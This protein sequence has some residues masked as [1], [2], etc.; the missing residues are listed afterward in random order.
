MPPTPHPP[1]IERLTD[2]PQGRYPLHIGTCTELDIK[3][4][5]QGYDFG[6]RLVHLVT[7]ETKV[8][9][10]FALPRGI[11]LR[12]LA[13]YLEYPDEYGNV[14]ETGV[15]CDRAIVWLIEESGPV[16]LTPR[17]AWVL[18]YVFFTLWPGQK[19]FDFCLPNTKH[20]IRC[21]GQF[22]FLKQRIWSAE[23]NN[24]DYD[25][26]YE[27][28]GVNSP[29]F[30]MCGGPDNT[31][32]WIPDTSL[33]STARSPYE[34]LT[35]PGKL[36]KRNRRHSKNE[37]NIQKSSDF[38]KVIY[39]RFIPE[40]KSMLIYRSFHPE[41]DHETLE[42]CGKPCSPYC[43]TKI[44]GELSDIPFGCVVLNDYRSA[45]SFNDLGIEG[46]VA[47]QIYYIEKYQENARDILIALQSLLHM[48]FL[49]DP[50]S[51][52]VVAITGALDLTLIKWMCMSGGNISK[53]SKNGSP[54]SV[55]RI[56]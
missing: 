47:F 12:I 5:H 17:H 43:H 34:P 25:E 18:F 51:R 45:P 9:G 7:P 31:N 55:F 22:F 23:F 54:S 41:K 2:V 4:E 28:G 38:G 36:N 27:V 42:Q 52:S 32:A 44:I 11:R 56:A 33:I 21:M 29:S 14:Q 49:L 35:G 46:Q 16:L 50:S 30:W 26:Q 10:A 37:Q 24:Y 39:H 40:T 6:G 19:H 20:N 8:V 48:L 13:P 53:V 1:V 3:V 15:H